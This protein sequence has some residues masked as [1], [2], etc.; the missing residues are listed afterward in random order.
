MHRSFALFIALCATAGTS[1]CSPTKRA[2]SSSGFTSPTFSST[3]GGHGN[4]VT[5]LVPV[6]ITSTNSQILLD[7]PRSQNNVTELIQELAQVNSVL[8]QT[9]TGPQYTLQGT[10]NIE[11]TL[12]FPA[13]SSSYNGTVQL[14]T[15]GVGF[16]KT[17]WDIAPG[18]SYQDFAAQKGYATVAYNRLGVGR[19]DKPDPLQVVQSYAEVEILHGLIGLLRSGKCAQTIFKRI[20]AV[21]HSYGSVVQL[22]LNSKYPDDLDATIDTGMSST[23]AYLLGAILS[24]DPTVAALDSKTNA[25]LP[26]AYLVHASAIAISQAFL[27]YPYYDPAIL[28]TV[29]RNKGLYTFGQI[30]TLP[31]IFAPAKSYA[32]PVFIVL[33]QNDFTF[34]GGDC[35]YGGDQA[36]ITLSSFYPAAASG[37]SHYLVA[38]AGH[39]INAQFSA[40][41]AFAQQISFLQN[42][43]L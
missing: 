38:N 8:G 42:N 17:Y 36:A 14:L 11:A 6:S 33:G 28:A 35:N 9:V 10:Y 16:D 12:C 40:G 4:C 15:H 34:C 31:G 21:G 19:S 5:G 25:N 18:Y 26:Y 43:G 32:K 1:D 23:L 29:T 37:S 24:N 7:E 13:S 41:D 2:P 30:F 39:A 20:V 22:G 27:R 3:S